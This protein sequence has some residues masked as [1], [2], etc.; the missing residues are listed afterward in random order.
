MSFFPSFGGVG[1]SKDAAPATANWLSQGT[2]AI[3]S[4]QGTE[5]CSHQAALTS[6]YHH[7]L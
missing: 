6:L 7:P 3:Q 2:Q 1:V 4:P 5:Q